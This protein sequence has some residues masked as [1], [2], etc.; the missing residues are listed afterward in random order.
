MTPYSI[1]KYGMT[2]DDW[3]SLMGHQR[4]RCPLCERTFTK[5]VGAVVDHDHRTGLV[6]GL[7]CRHC[8]TMLGLLHDNADWCERSSKYLRL[9]PCQGAY[10]HVDAPPTKEQEAP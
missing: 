1:K 7:L 9:P 2:V 3:Q 5:R 10:R 8:N 4:G 6:R